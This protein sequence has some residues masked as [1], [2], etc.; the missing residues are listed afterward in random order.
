MAHALT[1]LTRL[2][3]TS[4]ALFYAVD[5]RLLKF[6]GCVVVA[7]SA[8]VGDELERA[9]FGYRQRHQAM[10]PLSPRRQADASLSV[11]D[12]WRVRDVDAIRS[13]YVEEYLRPL[14]LCGQT[15]LHLR[16]MGRII[17]GIDL[18][19]ASGDPELTDSQLAL[20]RASQPLIEQAYACAPRRLGP[21][22]LARDQ[23][24]GASW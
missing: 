10:D 20:L 19:R 16:R 11:L 8:R 5:G 9:L 6:A 14:R 24:R 7:P 15:T 3:P 13:R 12:S 23:H 1:W 18:M 4:L 2:V 17:A 22:G 21:A